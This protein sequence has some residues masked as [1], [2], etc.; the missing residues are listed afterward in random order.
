MALTT[1]HIRFILAVAIIVAVAPLCATSMVCGSCSEVSDFAGAHR[2]V[3]EI[4]KRPSFLC[5]SGVAASSVV[6]AVAR[7]RGP[8]S[9]VGFVPVV[10][11]PLAPMRV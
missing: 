1:S 6:I 5:G 10:V 2:V 7:F 3:G 8:Y 11:P 4:V 9:P